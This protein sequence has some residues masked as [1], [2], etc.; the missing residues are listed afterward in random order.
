MTESNLPMPMPRPPESPGASSIEQ[1]TDKPAWPPAVAPEG[2]ICRS[3]KYDL[4]G[5]PVIA[6]DGVVRCPECA[7]FSMVSQRPQIPGDPAPENIVAPTFQPGLALSAVGA[8]FAVAGFFYP[9]MPFAAMAMGACAMERSGGK[10]GL[11]T[12]IFA[13]GVLIISRVLLPVMWR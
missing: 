7:L 8:I 11:G 5:L 6:P 10:R 13:L 4:S 2:M 1:S 3:C 12:I 9:Y